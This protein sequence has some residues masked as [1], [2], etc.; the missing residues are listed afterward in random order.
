MILES[1]VSDFLCIDS[2][3]DFSPNILRCLN[4]SAII[5][6]TD[7]KG[8]IVFVNELFCKISGYDR[9]EL[10]GCNHRLINSGFHTK[11]FF[12]EMWKLIK[13]NQNWKGEV[14]NRKKSG[15]R[16]WVDST[17][18]PI[19][20]V[21]GEILYL[22]IRYDITERKNL[23][24]HLNQVSRYAQIGKLAASVA[25]EINNPLAIIV[26][27]IELLQ[28]KF[29]KMPEMPKAE[30]IV[31]NRE[32][33]L[34][35]LSRIEYGAKRISTFV[36]DM[37]LLSDSRTADKS[38]IIFANEFLIRSQ[39]FFRS[40]IEA[41]AIK[42]TVQEMPDVK[43]NIVVSQLFHVF[44]NLVENAEEF[45]EKLDNNFEKRIEISGKSVQLQTPNGNIT[46]FQFSVKNSG[47]K[48]NDLQV[49]ENLKRPMYSAKIGDHS[50]GLGLFMCHSIVKKMGGH[51]YLSKSAAQTCFQ[52]ELPVVDYGVPG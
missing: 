39:R 45:L 47:P 18:F 26:G 31:K 50:Q 21:G 43:L 6:I 30:E 20:A 23:E 1:N 37:V 52:I 19:K 16:Y 40:R 36:K 11:S 12:Q 32:L 25:H 35:D 22:S 49:I 4:Q 42:L 2:R 28:K 17:I 46:F 38:E 13:T 33:C 41:K 7:N 27:K 3:E 10:I 9:D 24:F 51:F 48:L 8:I 14:C 29:E 34:K 44:N 15:E 5:S